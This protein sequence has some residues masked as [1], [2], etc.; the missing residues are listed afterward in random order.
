MPS[1]VVPVTFA[2]QLPHNFVNSLHARTRN[3]YSVAVFSYTQFKR[4]P[5]IRFNDEIFRVKKMKSNLHYQTCMAN[6]D[7]FVDE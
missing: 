7:Y 1:D 2:D 4:K 5:M 6:F 3:V